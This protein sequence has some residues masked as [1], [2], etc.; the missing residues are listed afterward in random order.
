MKTPKY[1]SPEQVG[2]MFMASKWTVRRW[3]EAGRLPAVRVGRRW[4]IPAEAVEA[5]GQTVRIAD[6]E[7]YEISRVIFSASGFGGGDLTSIILGNEKPTL[8]FWKA[9]AEGIR[10]LQAE[11]QS[12]AAEKRKR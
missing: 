12:L 8:E 4:L 10:L 2:K 5:I 1:L 9:L 7:T 11:N 3:I 6:D